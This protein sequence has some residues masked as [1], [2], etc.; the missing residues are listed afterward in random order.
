MQHNI[1]RWK[2]LMG[3]FMV[4]YLGR[5][6]CAQES[7]A[8][9]P[10][11]PT[12]VSSITVLD[13][14]GRYVGRITPQ[15]RY[16]VSID[17]IPAFLQQ[18]LLAVEDSRFYEHNGIDYRG[19]ARAVV[20]DVLKGKMAQGGSTITQQ[21]IKNKYLNSDKT[22][23]RKLKEAEMALEFEKR[24]TKRQILEMYFNEI[25]YG[26]GAF[27]IAQ[28]ARLYFDKSPEELTEGESI[29][30]AGVPKNPRRYNPFG[31]PAYVVQRR[32]IVLQRMLDLNLIT[33]KRKR[34]LQIHGAGTRTLGQAPQYLAQIR[35]Q[36]IGR[37]GVDAVEIGGI[38]VIAAMDL[39]LQKQAEQALRNGVRRISPL[40]QGALVCM[41]PI[42]GDV[43]AAVGD[44][45][46]VK[47]SINR[48]FISRRQTGSAIK[49]LIYAAA[50]EK[51]I[52]AASIWNDAPASYDRGNGR[53]WRPQNYG[54]EHFGEISLRQA[55]AHSDNIITVKVLEAVGV[56]AFVEFAGKMGLTLH[57]QNGL[58]LALGTE[59]VTLKDLVQSYTPLPTGGNRAEARTILRFYDRRL[60]TWS[61]NPPI[62][63]P[64]LAPA[65][66]FITTQMLKDVMTYGTA[67][68]LKR[69]S[70][71][72]PSAGKTGTTDN[73][74][75]AWFVGYTP[76]LLT[77][78]WVGN[79]RPKSGGKGFTGGAIAAPIWESFMNKAVAM[80][81]AE[82]FARPETV[83][84]LLIDPTT[85]L[86]SREECPQ[87]QEEFFI[88][89]TEPVEFCTTHGG[90]P[91]Q[92][93]TEVPA[94]VPP[95]PSAIVED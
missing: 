90:E 56:P 19:I 78:I 81:P 50:L 12:G 75:D 63:T 70:E 60:K 35:N 30:L 44:A 42:T 84:S 79:D 87:K 83:V 76:N 95:A 64:V 36:L 24:Y 16:W 5:T 39:D 72:H 94:V 89:G 11:L 28:A 49:P 67:K 85:G 92:Q 1:G 66:A 48:A 17:R 80:R 69:F 22:I 23:D 53:F 55:L 52:T 68:G 82:D 46:G 37:L 15:K 27:G 20:T 4:L 29:L 10:P 41:D 7:F 38:E 26:N 73:Y 25:Y 9:Y 71:A 3:L 59:E 34:D 47:N 86:P 13:S 57:A 43:L 32:E 65:A 21:L 33:A 91:I 51:G 31:K 45:D 6:I 18:A 54:N 93:D 40:L 14:K 61:E 88:A 8:T 74:K 58:S 2:P 77:G 62:T